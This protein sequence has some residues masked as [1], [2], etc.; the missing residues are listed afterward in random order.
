MKTYWKV[1]ATDPHGE[2]VSFMLTLGLV[3]HDEAKSIAL[4]AC[5]A[6]YLEFKRLEQFR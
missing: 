5:A 2:E 3:S 1:T 6:D 4:V